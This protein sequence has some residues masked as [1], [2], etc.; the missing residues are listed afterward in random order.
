MKTKMRMIAATVLAAG[1]LSGMQTAN[2]G[3]Q[4]YV[5]HWG[6]ISPTPDYARSMAYAGMDWKI[7]TR[8]GDTVRLVRGI[9]IEQCKVRGGY[10]W[11]CQASIV[12]DRCM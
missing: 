11:Q 8:L 2:A 6:R 1:F 9:R 4:D 12:I 3:C 5:T 10:G 7:R